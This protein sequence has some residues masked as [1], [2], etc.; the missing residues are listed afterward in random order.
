MTNTTLSDIVPGRT[1]WCVDGSWDYMNWCQ[2]APANS[3]EE[4]TVVL[5]EGGS[6]V[7]SWV[8][9]RRPHPSSYHDANRDR[10]EI[11]VFKKARAMGKPMVGTCR[12]HQLLGAL[13]GALLVQ[14]QQNRARHPI[15]TEDGKTIMVTSSHHQAVAP[16]NLSSDDFRLIGWSKGESPYHWG[17]YD[18][19]ELVIGAAPDDRE[20]EIIYWPK[21][22]CLGSQGHIEWM[23]PDYDRSATARESVD[24]HRSLLNR[25]L[26]GTL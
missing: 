13:N 11:E 3:M 19:D 24:Y 9:N 16:W 1:V 2:A 12:G 20:T 26:D 5:F 14:D 22:R 7:S 8:Y 6:D 15:S 10:R 25:L 23:F 18:G 21:T 4:A 17:E